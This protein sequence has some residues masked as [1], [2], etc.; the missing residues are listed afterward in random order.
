ME[1][2]MTTSDDQQLLFTDDYLKIDDTIL[3]YNKIKNV[4][5]KN[6]KGHKLGENSGFMFLYEDKNIFIPCDENEKDKMLPFFQIASDIEKQEIEEKLKIE[7]EKKK[8]EKLEKERIKQEK[9]EKKKLKQEQQKIQKQEKPIIIPA[10]VQS[11][12][13]I[14]LIQDDNYITCKICGKKF[15]TNGFGTHIKSH[16]LTRKEHDNMNNILNN[17]INK[18]KK[19]KLTNETKQ[20][21]DSMGKA[22]IVHRIKRLSDGQLGGWIEYEDNLS[23]EGNCWVGDEAIV[24]GMTKVYENAQVFGHAI[25][26]GYLIADIFGNAK[27]YGHAKII[28]WSI[29]ICDNVEIYDDAEVGDTSYINGNVKI[30]GDAY[31]ESCIISN[32]VQIYDHAKIKYIEVYDSVQ[33]CGYSYIDNSEVESKL[34]ING[35][36]KLDSI[37]IQ[38][39]LE[40]YDTRVEED[41]KEDSKKDKIETTQVNKKNRKASTF[42]MLN[43]PVNS[44]LVYIKN[45]SI[46][47]KVYDNKN[48]VQHPDGTI[49]SISGMVKYIEQR[50]F[51]V[52]G[53]QN[54]T[55]NGKLLWDIR[56]E[57]ENK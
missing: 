33:I 3:T 11:K 36:N 51:E 56:K 52:N 35:S 28:A 55:Y 22:H 40:T 21:R 2:Y 13:Q 16:G 4:R 24:F 48:L 34:K 54:F 25:I 30:Y 50:D 53:N 7:E 10:K 9:L 49:K 57:L 12:N 42:E 39:H 15:H 29:K 17:N 38:T 41:T 26:N 37:N 1:M 32:F 20:I 14:P 31:I 5:Y 44:E 19:Y 47:V 18:T 46:K 45:P 23:H 43:I 8:K 27:I 6:V